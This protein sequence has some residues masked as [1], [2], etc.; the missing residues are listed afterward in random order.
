VYNSA[1]ER[2]KPTR[3]PPDLPGAVKAQANWV[4]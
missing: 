1:T 2:P 3:G 4:Y